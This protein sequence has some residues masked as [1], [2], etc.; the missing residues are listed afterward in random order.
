MA[1]MP[2]DLLRILL[3]AV[4]LIYSSLMD[5]KTREV[6]NWTWVVFAPLGLLLD[7]YEGLYLRAIDPV[8]V[9]AIP[10]LIST[11]L[12]L[13]FYYG[14]LY[15]GA[16]AKAFITLSLLM[17][18]PPEV[19]KPY[20]MVVSPFY[21]LTV[22][23][24]SALI[25]VLFALLLLTKNLLW[26]SR[27]QSILFEGMGEEPLWKK[28]LALLSCLK[29]EA[30]KLRGPPYQYPAEVVRDSKRRLQLL[31]NTTADEEAEE[32]FRI[33]VDDLGLRELWVSPTLPFLIF[34]SLGFLCSLLLGDLAL[35]AL[36]KI[37]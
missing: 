26:G 2:L 30:K 1:S 4:M 20:L 6:S 17:P 32:T 3:C 11:G 18:H 24:D 23:T 19:I 28:S 12:S 13:A 27:S 22:F 31:P 7:L 9:L 34:I 5:L 15:G 37:F 33:L 10:V 21:P 14:R 8:K 36:N 25:A 29:V 16:D 35:W